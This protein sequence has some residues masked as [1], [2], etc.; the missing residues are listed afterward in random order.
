MNIRIVVCSWAATALAAIAGPAIAA[1]TVVV[2]S[3]TD[4]EL[5]EPLIA[6]F[7]LTHPDIKV[8]YRELQSSVLYNRFLK[9]A[10]T[11]AQADIVWSSA[12]DLQM[13]LV[14]DGYARPHRSSETVA[15]PPWAVWN[16]E[17]FGTTFEPVG[18]AYNRRSLDAGAIPQT[19]AELI[20]LLGERPERFRNRI[21]T[22]SPRHSGLGYLL[23]S[24][25]LEA[26]PVAFWTLLQVLDRVGL[27]VEMTTN[28]MLDRIAEGRALLGYNVLLSYALVRAR[29]DPRIGVVLPK[30]YTLVMSR[31]IFI[32]RDAPHPD[33]AKAWLDHVLSKRGQ[34]VLNRAG[35][36]SVR[37]DIE[38]EGSA[39]M[40]R[41]ELGNAFR[42][43][44]L[45]T[46]LLTYL[47]QMK[48]ELF[49]TRWDATL[50]GR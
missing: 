47:D 2:Y 43:I 7:E 27:T 25:D 13:K 11:G 46:G 17:A 44:A 6:D 1:S 33:A 16:N 40:L 41:K 32:N 14:N 18:F 8:D 39:A 15:L 30:D 5:V 23:H 50:K 19:H 4:R 24:Q 35:F 38:G 37:T 48:R 10:E 49:L 3:A 9:E 42:P 21:T 28:E 34:S 29:T 31:I 45:N 20:R 12:M 26:N 22:Y 36:L